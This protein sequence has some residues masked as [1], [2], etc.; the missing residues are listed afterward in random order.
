MTSTEVPTGPTRLIILTATA[1]GISVLLAA[2]WA[3]RRRQS[4]GRIGTSTPVLIAAKAGGEP[5]LSGSY[6]LVLTPPSVTGS[7]TEAPA[8]PG[9][10]LIHMEAA[11]ST[12]TQSELWQRRALAAE[13]RAAQA[14]EALRAGAL[15]HL[16]HW[17][18]THLLQRLVSDRSRL[19]ETQHAAALK[20]M[21]VDERLQKIES[22]LQQQNQAYLD[23]I[24][25]LT[26]Q[27]IAAKEENREL[28]LAQITQVKAE[29]ETAR[30]RLLSQA[31][32]RE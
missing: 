29:M 10:P 22:Q 2:F 20:A 17:L 11:G 3:S 30:A 26:S 5:E 16:R 14:H 13:H 28:I 9:Q 25:K 24:E 21:A 31:H 7:S 12:H 8:H 1:A 18:K 19:L 4:L 32:A 23:R 27:L 6:T 15:G